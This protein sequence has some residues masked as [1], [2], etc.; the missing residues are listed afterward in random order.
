MRRLHAQLASQAEAWRAQAELLRLIAECAHGTRR[1][2]ELRAR[3]WPWPPR[4][5]G[6][7]GTGAPQPAPMECS[8]ALLTAVEAYSAEVTQVGDAVWGLHDQAGRQREFAAAAH[9]AHLEAAREI[10]QLQIQ[11]RQHAVLEKAAD[12]ACRQAARAEQEARRVASDVEEEA[13]AAQ[14]ERDLL[15]E[16]VEAGVSETI[17]VA[18]SAAAEGAAEAEAAEEEAAAAEAA[19]EAEAAEARGRRSQAVIDGEAAATGPIRE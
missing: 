8:A 12:T 18:R 6:A 16:A 17:E 1:N 10:M 7:G 9:A 19:A 13:A 2:D 11:L 5:D 3:R 15:A 4:G 14:A